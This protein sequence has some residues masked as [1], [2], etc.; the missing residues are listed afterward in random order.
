MQ[1]A[2]PLNNPT[3][4]DDPQTASISN[5]VHQSSET[6]K[7]VDEGDDNKPDEGEGSEGSDS[8]DSDGSDS[9]DSDGSD[10][11]DGDRDGDNAGSDSAG[12]HQASI[13]GGGGIDL[14]PR[15]GTGG[16]CEVVWQGIVPKRLFQGFKFQEVKSSAAARK[17][18]EGKNAVHY[19]DMIKQS[20][21]ARVKKGGA[22]SNGDDGFS[23]DIFDFLK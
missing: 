9:D 6:Q 3:N 8:E 14:Q 19:W 13:Y 22:G 20:A 5:Q 10:S 12:Q 4:T 1:A 7:Q 17:T 18:L 2:D 15:S 21:V 11:E 23:G 16:F